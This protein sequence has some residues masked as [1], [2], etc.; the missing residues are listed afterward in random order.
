MDK[1]PASKK[2]HRAA[3]QMK[4]INPGSG[5][6]SSALCATMPFTDNHR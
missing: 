2:F 1:V 6:P 3:M 5:A 4:K